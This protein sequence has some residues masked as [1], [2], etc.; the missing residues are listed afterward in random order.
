M[1]H[2]HPRYPSQ[3]EGKSFKEALAEWVHTQE[4]V[5]VKTP[6]VLTGATGDEFDKLVDTYPDQF[7]LYCGVLGTD[8]INRL[9]N[10][11]RR[12]RR[13]RRSVGLAYC[14]LCT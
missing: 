3:V 1:F 2:V 12:S 5:G 7:Q 8:I 6:V 11:I 14:G 13:Y 10:R 9:L 4:E